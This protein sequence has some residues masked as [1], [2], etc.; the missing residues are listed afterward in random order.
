MSEY[1]LD[2][3]QRLEAQVWEQG[4]HLMVFFLSFLMYDL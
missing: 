4:L 1:A 2:L 3:E